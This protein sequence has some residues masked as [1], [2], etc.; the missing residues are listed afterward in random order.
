MLWLLTN[1]KL[2]LIGILSALLALTFKLWRDEARA[3]AVRWIARRCPT[4]PL[5]TT[6]SPAPGGIC[7][8]ASASW[9]PGDHCSEIIN[10]ILRDNGAKTPWRFYSDPPSPCAMLK[11]AAANLQPWTKE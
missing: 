1:W 7:T 3:F 4:T 8:F 5:S 9:P 6:R 2:V 10:D 11:W